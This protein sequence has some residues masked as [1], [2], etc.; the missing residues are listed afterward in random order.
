MV[1]SGYFLQCVKRSHASFYFNSPFAWNE[2]SK[3]L[4]SFFLFYL[5]VQS[6]FTIVLT[7]SPFIFLFTNFRELI[8]QLW[9]VL[10]LAMLALVLLGKHLKIFYFQCF[11]K[12]MVY[13][14]KCFDS[15]VTE[16]VLCGRNA[17]FCVLWIL[18]F[19]F[20]LNSMFLQ[21]QFD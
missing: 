6:P 4:L 12:Y 5:Q 13:H 7:P 10:F 3:L 14:F 17:P 1:D 15:N 21:F 20:L 9:F 19:H 18:S 8:T 11:F 2:S 16:R